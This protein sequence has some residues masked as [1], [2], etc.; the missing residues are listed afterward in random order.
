VVEHWQALA[1][2]GRN[3]E[4]VREL[5]DQHYDPIYLRSMQRNFAGFAQALA[6]PL[7]DGSPA[8][9]DA[10]VARLLAAPAADSARATM[11]T[12]P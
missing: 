7:A 3:A 10:A 5:L 12:T 2:A 1:R 8:A 11:S 9:M 6:V 4:L